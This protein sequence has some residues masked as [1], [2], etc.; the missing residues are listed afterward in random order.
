MRSY[1]TESG[2]CLACIESDVTHI[3]Q[4]RHHRTQSHPIPRSFVPDNRAPFLR[5]SFLLHPD[6]IL[7]FFEFESNQFVVWISIPVIFDEKVEGFDFETLSE[8]E[9]R[10]FGDELDTDED[11]ESERD[12][13]DVGN[14]LSKT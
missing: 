11:I 3:G 5:F 2:R 9:T 10:G 14:A 1:E 12:L 6:R 4:E 13:E 8:K 7:H